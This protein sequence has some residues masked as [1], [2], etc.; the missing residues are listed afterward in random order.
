MRVLNLFNQ[1][2]LTVIFHI[3]STA[4]NVLEPYSTVHA[5]GLR[6]HNTNSAPLNLMQAPSRE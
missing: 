6:G 5:A 2:H 1:E 4:S 3:L